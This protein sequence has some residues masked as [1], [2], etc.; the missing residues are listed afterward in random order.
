MTE[1]REQARRLYQTLD[2]QDWAALA[3]LVSPALEVQLGSSPPIGYAAWEGMLKS[4][5]TGFP[6]GHH[7]IDAYLEEGDRV[8][9][10]CRFQGTHKGSFRGV[11]PTGSTISVGVIHIDRFRDGKLMEHVG[12]LDALGLLQQIGARGTAVAE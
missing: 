6:D 12:Q 3:S 10:R 5:F 1:L 7:V 4:F 8:V 9:T 11:A 2:S